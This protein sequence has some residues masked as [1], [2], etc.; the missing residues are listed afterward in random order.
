MLRAWRTRIGTKVIRM[1][2][3]FSVPQTTVLLL[4]LLLLLC[5]LPTVATAAAALSTSV[6]LVVFQLVKLQACPQFWCTIA[7]QSQLDPKVAVTVYQT[8]VYSL[9]TVAIQLVHH[10]VFSCFSACKS[11]SIST[12]WFYLPISNIGKGPWC[13][14]ELELKAGNFDLWVFNP[15]QCWLSDTLLY[16]ADMWNVL[17]LRSASRS[18]T[19]MGML[20][21]LYLLPSWRNCT[22]WVIV[23]LIVC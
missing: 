13:V 20:S 8:A 10:R 22:H 19:I 11:F 16:S 23:T 9:P 7:E 4:R 15:G 6:Y 18:P 21:F 12:I 3:L 14:S 17:G 2:F 5:S 1:A